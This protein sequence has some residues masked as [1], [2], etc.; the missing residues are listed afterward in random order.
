MCLRLAA[1]AALAAVP[2]LSLHTQSADYENVAA[3]QQP[4]LTLEDA[5]ERVA[6]IHPELRLF[7][8]RLDVLAA[9][10]ERAALRPP[11]VAGAAVENAFGTGAVRG[12]HGAELT[13]TLASVLERGG[14]LD[15]RRTLA[16]S[17]IDALA[18]ERE[19]RRLDL[20]AEIARRYLTIVAAQRQRQIA[21]LDI[22]QRERTIA[23]A[24]RRLEAGG[25][26][27]SA[28]LTAEA[29]LARAELDRARAEQQLAASRQRL[30]AMWGERAPRFRI[31]PADPTQLPTIDDFSTL[32][33][34]LE[35]S[36]EL[37]QFVGERR[38]REARLQ[39]ARAEATPDISWE[40]G[41][42]RL[43]A[44]DDF[45][46]IAGVSIPLG[47]ASRAKPDIRAARA[48]L[49]GLEIEREAAGLSLYS[50]LAEAHGRYRTAELEVVR[51]E[52]DVLPR[53]GQAEAAA[54]RAYRA[55]AASYLEWATLQS[56][57]T[58][59]RRLQLEAALDAQLALIEIQRLIGQ[60]FVA[61]EPVES[62][63]GN[64][65]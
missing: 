31:A 56:E 33:D 61:A 55:G 17:R 51:W 13:L 57:R 3:P 48:E 9:Q 14:K 28:V 35:S 63:R 37:E 54:E 24:R 43:E 25:S 44:A 26:P 58:D 60:P 23:A 6:E 59:A 64:S 38:I 45:G 21:Q 18:V 16:Q 50:T 47:S 1:I 41:V 46:L 53:L 2:G 42:R 22:E 8:S 4:V 36:P 27:E 34:L 40:V 29:A 7:G 12:L 32:A 20:L 15:A 62:G 65:R 49:A 39:L 52:N 11:L 10:R 19:A 5:F 30:A